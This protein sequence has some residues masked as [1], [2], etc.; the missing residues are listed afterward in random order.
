[1][2]STAHAVAGRVWDLS[3]LCLW[4][5]KHPTDADILHI[6]PPSKKM[7]YVYHK[8][9]V[10]YHWNPRD[11][12]GFCCMFQTIIMLKDSTAVDI[13]PPGPQLLF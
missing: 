11:F 13:G 6:G 5:G 2:F 7:T 1:M 3:S 9:S 12:D 4:T 10:V 8:C